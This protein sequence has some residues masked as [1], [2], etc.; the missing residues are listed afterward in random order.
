MFRQCVSVL[1]R[2]SCVGVSRAG[3]R[4]ISGVTT[5][6]R[7]MTVGTRAVTTSHMRWCGAPPL[8]SSSSS[9]PSA[10]HYSSQVETVN[11]N[12]GSVLRAILDD[13]TR[14]LVA[15]EKRVL[16]SMCERLASSDASDPDVLLL[17]K[18]VSQLDELFM[19]V[20]V[21]EFNSGKSSF[22][23]TL[24]GSSLAKNEKNQT[25]TLVV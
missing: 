2:G 11:K 24:L 4:Q 20:V 22:I 25:L 13:D 7:R 12:D 23:N 16:T 5:I 6:G 10:R 17:R 8:S 3:V 21:G 15:D 9:P 14:A 18:I 1:R 19:L